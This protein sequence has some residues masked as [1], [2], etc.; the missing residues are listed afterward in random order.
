MMVVIVY[1]SERG[2]RMMRI[3]ECEAVRFVSGQGC[4]DSIWFVA[5]QMT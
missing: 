2:A 1:T 3:L 4:S 5:L